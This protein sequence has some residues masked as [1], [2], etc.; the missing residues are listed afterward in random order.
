MNIS[1][2]KKQ[3]ECQYFSLSIISIDCSLDLTDCS[4]DLSDCS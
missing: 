4:L 3:P 1:Q 2:L